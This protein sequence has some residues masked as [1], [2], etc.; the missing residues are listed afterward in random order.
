[1]CIYIYISLSIYIYIYIYIYMYIHIYTRASP[2]RGGREGPGELLPAGPRGAA[3]ISGGGTNNKKEKHIY[4]ACILY[5]YIYIYILR[6]MKGQFAPGPSSNI[7][8]GSGRL[9]DFPILTTVLLDRCCL[10]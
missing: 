9:P 3:R 4:Y 2:R 1:M 7:N 5:I 8:H 10:A 6:V